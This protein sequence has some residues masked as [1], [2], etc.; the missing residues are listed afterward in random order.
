[1]LLKLCLVV[2]CFLE[3]GNVLGIFHCCTVDNR[4]FLSKWHYIYV[5]NGDFLKGSITVEQAKDTY[6]Y[7]VYT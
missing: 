7:V 2:V 4:I 5:Y 6:V 1:M 3:S